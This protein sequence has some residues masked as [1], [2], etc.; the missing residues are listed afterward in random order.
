MRVEIISPKLR[1]GILAGCCVGAVYILVCWS[2]VILGSWNP[3]S[4]D[5]S[6]FHTFSAWI[7]D[8]TSSFPFGYFHIVD[9]T[10]ITPIANGLLWGFLAAVV[11]IFLSRGKSAA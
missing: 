10:F 11:F 9:G 6:W 4:G 5:F 2:L 8:F 3:P 1:R 7:L